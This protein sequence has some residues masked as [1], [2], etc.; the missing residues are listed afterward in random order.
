MSFVL[1]IFR[2]GTCI[3]HHFT[4]LVWLPTRIFSNPITHFP[5]L[6]P[7]FFAL[8]PH[9]LVP[10][11]PFLAMC[12]VVLRGF[13]Y[14]IAVYFYAFC[15]SFSSILPCV[16]R[17]NVLHLAPK[18]IAFSTKT[19]CI[20]RQNTLRLAPKRTAFCSKQPEN[21]YKWRLL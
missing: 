7:Y 2:L 3:M 8:K 4:F 15:L 20:Q 19:H 16:Q 17:Q 10:I 13:I 14:T 18:R 11:L 1:S 12:F 5:P 6:K 9:L 21:G